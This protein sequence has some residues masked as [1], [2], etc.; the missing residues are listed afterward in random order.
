[1]KIVIA[2][3]LSDAVSSLKIMCRTYIRKYYIDRIYENLDLLFVEVI[4]NLNYRVTQD[5]QGAL[6]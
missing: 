2:Y 5:R 4:N 1:M 3:L 6:F